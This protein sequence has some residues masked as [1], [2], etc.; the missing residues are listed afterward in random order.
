MR[1]TNCFL[2]RKMARLRQEMEAAEITGDQFL[3]TQSML[4]WANVFA[5]PT[6]FSV[7]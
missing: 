7:C 3:W 6:P 5:F 2:D 1:E 4:R